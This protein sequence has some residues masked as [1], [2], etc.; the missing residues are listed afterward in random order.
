METI[1]LKTPV[2]ILFIFIFPCWAYAEALD[3]MALISAGEFVMGWD[4][5]EDD[6]KPAHTVFLD[7]F[8]I[9]LHEVTQKAF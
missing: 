1:H 6:E 2:W 5:G 8:Y 3:G 9:S 4:Q 7:A